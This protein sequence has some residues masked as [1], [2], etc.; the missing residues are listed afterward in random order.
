ML[1]LKG[2]E[3]LQNC[4]TW[5]CDL[6]YPDLQDQWWRVGQWPSSK[7]SDQ[8]KR[9]GAKGGKERRKGESKT[10]LCRF[11][12]DALVAVAALFA[13]AS[14]QCYAASLS[15]CMNAMIQI[16]LFAMRLLPTHNA[17]QQQSLFP[18]AATVCMLWKMLL[19]CCCMFSLF[20][21]RRICQFMAARPC[22]VALFV[23]HCHPH[24]DCSGCWGQVA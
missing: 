19:A 16:S 2:M 12:Q 23:V 7:P 1:G 11:T 15:L 13:M 14:M 4:L 21:F 5:N 10:S 22:N 24:V 9:R 6:V 8:C 17:H 20:A 18:R 3:Q